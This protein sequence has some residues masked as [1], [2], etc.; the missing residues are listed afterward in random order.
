MPEQNPI[1]INKVIEQ[2]SKRTS[3]DD[4]KQKGFANVKV[5][6]EK[7]IQN[8]I[9]RAI[10]RVV[11]TQT[12]GERSRILAASRKELDRLMKEQ[13]EIKSG[14]QLLEA[15]KTE[16]IAQVES[17][18][19]LPVP[20]TQFSTTR[21]CGWGAEPPPRPMERFLS[22]MSGFPSNSQPRK[23]IVPPWSK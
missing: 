18:Q 19:G 9:S 3:L 1:D 17:L 4:L 7:A 15:D 21:A 11:V 14:Q 22:A 5:L 20:N 6:D 12:S 10:G 16:L 2:G 13:R 8:L 23:K